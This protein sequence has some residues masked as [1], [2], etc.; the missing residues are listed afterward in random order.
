LPHVE[1]SGRVDEENSSLGSDSDDEFL[2]DLSCSKLLAHKRWLTLNLLQSTTNADVLENLVNAY[3]NRVPDFF[4]TLRKDGEDDVGD[5]DGDDGIEPETEADAESGGLTSGQQQQRRQLQPQPQQPRQ[6]QLN[7]Q[8]TVQRQP[9]SQ[10]PQGSLVSG[11][12]PPRQPA[13]VRTALATNNNAGDT[14]RACLALSRQASAASDEDDHSSAF[15]T[16]QQVRDINASCCSLRVGRACSTERRPSKVDRK[17]L[18]CQSTHIWFEEELDTNPARSFSVDPAF[19]GSVRRGHCVS[20]CKPPDTVPQAPCGRQS[21]MPLLVPLADCNSAW[22]HQ[23]KRCCRSPRRPSHA[24]IPGSAHSGFRQHRLNCIAAT[25]PREF[26]VLRTQAESTARDTPDGRCMIEGF[27]KRNARTSS[28]PA[29]E[30]E[31]QSYQ[32]QRLVNSCE[33]W[34]PRGL[35]R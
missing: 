33:V 20:N 18:I 9:Q 10:L 22:R 32:Q 26:A 3:G 1:D 27:A 13:V 25:T 7:S 31:D 35:A 23:A 24:G 19:A 29:S 15:R 16:S 21:P 8:I 11:S 6:V 34:H 28:K 17:Q 5:S 30:P 12:R 2:P 14:H 4:R